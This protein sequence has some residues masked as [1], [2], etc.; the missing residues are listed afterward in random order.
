MQISRITRSFLISIAESS[1]APMTN[2]MRRLIAVLTARGQDGYATEVEVLYFK[3]L[4]DKME[5]FA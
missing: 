3:D 1:P 2:H 5:G 4:I